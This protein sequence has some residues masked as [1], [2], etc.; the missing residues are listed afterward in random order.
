MLKHSMKIVERVFEKRIRDRVKYNEMQFGFTPGKGAKDAIFKLRQ[1]QEK[2]EANGKKIYC[3]FV[4][5]EKA[6]DRIPREVTRW[7]LRK[8]G[9]EEWIV[10][11][12]TGLMAMYDEA[13]TV[14]RT[15]AG[16]SEG[17]EVRVGLHQ[18]SVLSQLLFVLVME[19]V[20]REI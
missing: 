10:R 11:G 18:G 4:D 9:V 20:T 6:Y 3:A 15:E 13:W 12:V 14:V 19:A 5:L 1:M 17:F 2:F 8:L 16:D 7:A